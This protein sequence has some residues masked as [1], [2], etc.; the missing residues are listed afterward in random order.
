[1]KS[2]F[3]SAIS[4]TTIDLQVQT[5]IGHQTVK[6]TVDD[7][8]RER[9]LSQKWFAFVDNVTIIPYTDLGSPSHP[10]MTPLANYVLGIGADV[11][12]EKL[13][14]IHSSDYRKAKLKPTR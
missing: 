5:A 1:M 7:A 2:K 12:V 10:Y 14:G 11:Y 6:I 8:D 9:I 13:G 4:K 3:I